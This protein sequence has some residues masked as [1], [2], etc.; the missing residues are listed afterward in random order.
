MI[1]IS[2]STPLINLSVIGHLDLFHS[3]F[4]TLIIEALRRAGE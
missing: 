4:G 1:V 2:N 3:L